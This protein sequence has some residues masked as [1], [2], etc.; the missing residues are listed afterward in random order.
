[1]KSKNSKN[2]SNLVHQTTGERI[3]YIFSRNIIVYPVG[4]SQNEFYIESNNFG[5]IKR[6]NKKLTQKEVNNALAKTVDYYYNMLHE[7]KNL[8]KK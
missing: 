6:F 3:Y 8:N 1:M 2:K 7:N 4:I 5:I